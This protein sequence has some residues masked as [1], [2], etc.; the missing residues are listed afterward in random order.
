MVALHV[1]IGGW[2][3]RTRRQ[4][5]ARGAGLRESKVEREYRGKREEEMGKKKKS[6]PLNRF[7]ST[8]GVCSHKINGLDFKTGK[9]C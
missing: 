8:A 3:R 5:E 7:R 4:E 9:S 1:G 6:G 2:R